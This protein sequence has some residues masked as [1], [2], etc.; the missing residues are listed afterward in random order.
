M[1]V[2]L[3]TIADEV[4][5]TTMTVSYA[6]RGSPQVSKETR[7][8]VLAVAK[9]LGYRPNASARAIR[10]GRFD[11]IAVLV[12]SDLRGG[13]L[14]TGMLLVL[15]RELSLSFIT[16]FFACN[17]TVVKEPAGALTYEQVKAATSDRFT[18]FSNV[19]K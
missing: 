9:R 12:D 18:F 8:K 3:R 19:K 11:C 15:Q 13:S 6:L 7:A 10:S 5:M 2:T 4:G 1:A 16:G 14:S 17:S